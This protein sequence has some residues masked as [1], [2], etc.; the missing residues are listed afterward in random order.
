MDTPGELLV[1][2]GG[3]LRPSL[4]AEVP[5]AAHPS[6]Q[7]LPGPR[8]CSEIP[9]T[10]LGEQN[11]KEAK[12]FT[13]LQKTSSEAGAD[14]EEKQG[15]VVEPATGPSFTGRD[16]G[17]DPAETSAL[18]QDRSL[19]AGQPEPGNDC[20]AGVTPRTEA[21]RR[22]PPGAGAGSLVLGK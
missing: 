2:R 1:T 11:P 18:Q 20:A 21:G 12:E 16:K 4:P 7:D 10:E 15:P 9:E 13:P 22:T 6:E 14:S 19:G 5:A 17:D 3:S 8:C